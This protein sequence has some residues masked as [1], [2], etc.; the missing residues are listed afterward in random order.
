MPANPGQKFPPVIAGNPYHE[1][2]ANSFAGVTVIERVI[3]VA[4][5]N[6]A[7]TSKQLRRERRGES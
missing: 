4:S 3:H 1:D 7:M 2:S 6:L 5:K